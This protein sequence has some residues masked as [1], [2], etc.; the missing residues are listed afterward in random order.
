MIKTLNILV[1]LFIGTFIFISCGKDEQRNWGEW[2]I[3]G[4]NSKADKRGG[5]LLSND[6]VALFAASAGRNDGIAF[7]FNTKPTFNQTF[8]VVDFTTTPAANLGPNQ[9][10]IL[11]NVPTN[12]PSAYWSTDDPNNLLEVTVQNGKVR[13]D[14]SNIKFRVLRNTNIIE[15]IGS[16]FVQEK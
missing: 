6:T 10:Y 15:A 8:E 9:C 12:P 14:F 13:A 7:Y 2:N 3:E 4:F 16:G 5:V 1:C 11:I